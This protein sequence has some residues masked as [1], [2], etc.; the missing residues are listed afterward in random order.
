M[1]VIVNG[2]WSFWVLED[3]HR[4]GRAA[5]VECWL[6]AHSG[7]GSLSRVEFDLK[8]GRAGNR[9]ATSDDAVLG[10]AANSAQ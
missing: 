7:V 6:Q 2:I 3:H 4:H 8:W 10:Y 1:V 9:D 5:A